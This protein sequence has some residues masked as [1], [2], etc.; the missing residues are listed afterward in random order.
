MKYTQIPE[1]WA[2]RVGPEEE[3]ETMYR[4]HLNNG[5]RTDWFDLGELTWMVKKNEGRIITIEKQ[6]RNTL[7]AGSDTRVPEVPME[8]IN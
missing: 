4:L 6:L 1:G 3:T 7:P 8:E 5:T 2:P